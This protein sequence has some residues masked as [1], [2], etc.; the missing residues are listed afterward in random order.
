MA[1]PGG[2]TAQNTTCCCERRPQYDSGDD[3]TDGSSDGIQLRHH[4]S[5]TTATR[6]PSSTKLESGVRALRTTR[7][8]QQAKPAILYQQPSSTTNCF[9]WPK[10]CR[11]YMAHIP[12]NKLRA[13]CINQLT[14]R[15]TA[16][17][18][19]RSPALPRPELQVPCKK[20]KKVLAVL[21]NRRPCA[22]DPIMAYL[23]SV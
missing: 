20:L 5:A 8:V 16:T 15:A 7:L 23:F 12:T 19:N 9:C 2:S 6:A 22:G 11:Q 17:Q 13:E 3:L 10:R 21:L 14:T 4:E 1:N 18:V